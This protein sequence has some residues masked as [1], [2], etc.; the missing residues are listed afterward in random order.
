MAR[1]EKRKSPFQIIKLM[2]TFDL[3][4]HIRAGLCL[5]SNPQS[6]TAAWVVGTIMMDSTDIK[7]RS[8]KQRPSQIQEQ[9]Q[10][11]FV[12]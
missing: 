6:S 9:E 12:D 2:V 7:E 10:P 5:H 8:G 4:L 11:Q 3:W 1:R